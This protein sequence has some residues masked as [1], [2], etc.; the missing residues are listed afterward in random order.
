MPH[1]RKLMGK[2]KLAV[3]D[4]KIRICKVPEGE[5]NFYGS[6]PS[7]RGDWPRLDGS[8]DARILNA[9]RRAGLGSRPGGVDR[10]Q[11]RRNY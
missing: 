10:V 9:R 7:D 8:L 11:K 4:E 1:L 3:N 6:R 5:F 2:L